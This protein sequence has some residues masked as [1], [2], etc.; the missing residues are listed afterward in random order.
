MSA[1][2]TA[3][4]VSTPSIKTS[5]WVCAGFGRRAADFGRDLAEFGWVPTVL[6]V[7][8]GACEGALDPE[9]L[10]LVPD[11]LSVVRAPAWSAGVTRRFGI[12]DL[13]LRAMR[14][15]CHQAN[16]LLATGRFDVFFITSR[17]TG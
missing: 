12:G 5:E 6:T 1:R 16:A 4:T 7:E 13:G 10:A 2:A 3:P 14:G 8:A 11:T 15:L 9:L 17:L